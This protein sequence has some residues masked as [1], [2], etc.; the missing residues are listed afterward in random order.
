MLLLIG[1]SVVLCEGSLTIDPYYHHFSRLSLFPCNPP[2]FPALGLM[3]IYNVVAIIKVVQ[4]QIRDSILT[5]WRQ[6]GEG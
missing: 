2:P 3:L 5:K 6:K 1:L 4:N